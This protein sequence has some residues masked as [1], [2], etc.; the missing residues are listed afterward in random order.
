[1][2]TIQD[3]CEKL[4]MPFE[5]LLQG[6]NTNRLVRSL[7]YA[8]PKMDI[9]PDA[10]VR[11]ERNTISIYKPAITENKVQK[12]AVREYEE[13][14]N[15]DLDEEISDLGQDE[16]D[17]LEKQA[18]RECDL[19]NMDAE[20]AIQQAL[21]NTKDS[22]F[23]SHGVDPESATAL[24]EVE[25]MLKLLGIYLENDDRHTGKNN[26]IYFNYKTNR[27]DH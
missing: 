12:R 6:P 22:N 19:A 1:M 5:V 4:N 15:M 13:A 25:E 16:V 8:D 11:N 3:N 26:K 2:D 21:D 9:C 10:N 18:Q 27:S 20:D 23:Y 17:F 24:K 14:T 7:L